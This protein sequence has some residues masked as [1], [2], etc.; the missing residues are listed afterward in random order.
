[1]EN[2]EYRHF[3]AEKHGR[4]ANFDVRCLDASR[5]FDGANGSDKGYDELRGHINFVISKG[6]TRYTHGLPERKEDD[7]LD[8]DN[9]EKRTMYCKV[10]PELN[11]ELDERIHRYRDASSLYDHD[12][13]PLTGYALGFGLWGKYSLPRCGQKLG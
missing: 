5:R 2:A 6:D 1:M 4:Y 10:V 7:E 12:L 8:R 9:F 3:N 13:K 11:I